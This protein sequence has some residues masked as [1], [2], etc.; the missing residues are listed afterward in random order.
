MLFG[1]PL[2][3]MEPTALPEIRPMDP[4]AARAG[5]L[6]P[7]PYGGPFGGR[8]ARLAF[9]HD[10]E[11]AVEPLD[12]GIVAISSDAYFDTLAQRTNREIRLELTR[13]CA[14]YPDEDRRLWFETVFYGRA[15]RWTVARSVRPFSLDGGEDLVHRSIRLL[16][17]EAKEEGRFPSLTSVAGQVHV[18]TLLGRLI[19][20][21]VWHGDVYELTYGALLRLKPGSVPRFAKYMTWPRKAVGPVLRLYLPPQPNRHITAE[22]YVSAHFIAAELMRANPR[23]RAL[24][25]STWY[26]DPKVAEVSPHL[27]FLSRFAMSYGSI[28]GK[29]GTDDEV[30]REATWKSGARR[31]LYEAGRYAPTRYYR[32]WPRDLLL[33]WA[34]AAQARRR[35]AE[36]AAAAAG[37]DGVAVPV[38]ATDS[39]DVGRK[40]VLVV[41][42]DPRF[43]E[44]ARESVEREGHKAAVV[45]DLATALGLGGRLR[46]VDLLIAAMMQPNGG[47]GVRLAQELRRR[48]PQAQVLLTTDYAEGDESSQ[49]GYTIAG[50]RVVAKPRTAQEFAQ[51][52]HTHLAASAEAANAGEAGEAH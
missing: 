44:L 36:T 32:L 43:Q 52:I 35:P 42:G 14:A 33:R 51:L 2:G 9:I 10:T 26:L 46:H 4:H 20:L 13:R 41:D 6:S 1:F 19:P 40:V 21:G 28:I 34:D 15:I 17:G 27:A 8:D 30:V 49:S 47:N 3:V 39:D 5:G 31:R 24:F 23:I 50:A 22:D 48:N 38:P 25:Q 7:N 16:L 11:A 18:L 37:P 29:V 45:A 12:P